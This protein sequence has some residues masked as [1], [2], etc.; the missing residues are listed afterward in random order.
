MPDLPVVSLYFACLLALMASTASAATFT[1]KSVAMTELKGSFRTVV[2]A[3]RTKVFAKTILEHYSKTIITKTARILRTGFR[4][5]S[6][7]T[8]C[9][10]VTSHSTLSDGDVTQHNVRM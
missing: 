10:M 2:F 6:I 9:P 8:H 5:L 7:T 4:L 1:S 3:L